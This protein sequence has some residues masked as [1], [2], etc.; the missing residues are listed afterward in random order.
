MEIGVIDC[1]GG[2]ELAFTYGLPH[3]G[4][5]NYLSSRL[6]EFGNSIATIPSAVRGMFDDVK[7]SFGAYF[8]DEAIEA[9]KKALHNSGSE[10]NVF[11]VSAMLDLISTQN[12]N[13]ANQRWIMAE[14]TL[15]ALYHKQQV[16]GFSGSYVDMEPGSIGDSHY[17]YRRAIDGLLIEEPDGDFVCD[18]FCDDLEE[19]DT[20]LTIRE[21]VNIQLS[22]DFLRSHLKSKVEMLQDPTDKS[23]GYL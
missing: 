3:Q 4:T 23:G 1:T 13:L 8:S 5:V 18:I 21:Q 6:A 14:P 11:A 17:D 20:H 2:T 22:W 19:G 9:A 15:R 7:R 10:I 16:D 12:A